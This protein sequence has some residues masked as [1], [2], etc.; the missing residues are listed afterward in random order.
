MRQAQGTSMDEVQSALSEKQASLLRD[1]LDRR[2]DET[3]AIEAYEKAQRS[4]H[5]AVRK[6]LRAQVPA[7][8]IAERLNVTKGRVYQMRD[9]TR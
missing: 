6:A 1:V 8:L 7:V 3:N 4:L 5:G 2:G 9:G